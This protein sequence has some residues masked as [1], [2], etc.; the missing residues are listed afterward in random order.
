M[1]DELKMES[2][3]SRWIDFSMPIETGMLVWPDDPEITVTRVSDMAKGDMCNVS[4]LHM[5]THTGTHM[6]APLHFL[7]EGESIDQM[8]LDVGIG[9]ARVIAIENPGAVTA[10]ELRGYEVRGRADPVPHEELGRGL[11]G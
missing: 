1:S 5:G 7:A 11:R 8:P 2:R 10:E 4:R 6:D 9:P 3:G